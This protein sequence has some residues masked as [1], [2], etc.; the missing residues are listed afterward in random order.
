MNLAN[1]KNH[2]RVLET[3][4][5][6]CGEPIE[7]KTPD[8]NFVEPNNDGKIEIPFRFGFTPQPLGHD[9]CIKAQ[10]AESERKAAA[11]RELARIEESRKRLAVALGWPFER[12]DELNLSA[13]DGS[14][15][16]AR[17][18]TPGKPGLL[19]YGTP[20][21]GKTFTLRVIARHL[22]ER[23]DL[24]PCWLNVN[25]WLDSLRS[26]LDELERRT[27]GAEK[28]DVLFFDDLGAEK[29]TEWSEP[30]IERILTHRF[31]YRLPTFV[32]TNLTPS[33]F[34]ERFGQ[35]IVSRLAGL[36]ELTPMHGRDR[37]PDALR[38]QLAKSSGGN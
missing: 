11:E 12:F 26:N 29:L 38:S 13:L 34:A 1:I 15:E 17:S 18:W 37:R 33:G 36:C 31:D 32:S 30:R 8:G 28:S 27:A 25:R 7:W 14:L 20:G 35:R 2:M 23:F 22:Y 10:L 19:L 5:K 16:K 3:T 4:C 21:I 6:T 9:E 24:Y